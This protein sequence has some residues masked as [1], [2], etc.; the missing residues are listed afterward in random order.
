MLD[1]ASGAHPNIVEA[2]EEHILQVLATHRPNNT[3]AN[4][5]IDPIDLVRCSISTV[6]ILLRRKEDIPLIIAAPLH[7][8]NKTFEWR[9]KDDTPI[10]IIISAPLHVLPLSIAGCLRTIGNVADLAPI[11]LDGI[12]TADWSA[13]IT[14]PPGKSLPKYITMRTRSKETL[15]I[16]IAKAYESQGFC[17]RCMEHCVYACHCPPPHCHLARLHSSCRSRY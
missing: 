9:L 5:N 6:D 13:T 12:Y 1:V 10:P 3:L 15:G 14:I 17:D 8:D 11:V 4:D 2:A 16:F 7:H